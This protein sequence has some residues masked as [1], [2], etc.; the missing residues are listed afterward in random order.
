M[1]VDDC[2][3][4]QPAFYHGSIFSYQYSAVLSTKAMTVCCMP[5]LLSIMALCLVTSILQCYVLK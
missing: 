4:S 5:G 3:N 2:C 1:V